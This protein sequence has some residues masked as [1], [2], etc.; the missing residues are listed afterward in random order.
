[1]TPHPEVRGDLV[2]VRMDE[3]GGAGPAAVR[4]LF[5]S[6]AIWRL[7]LV[8]GV[9]QQVL[10]LGAARLAGVELI[11]GSSGT[12]LRLPTLT[13]S[14]TVRM[15]GGVHDLA[16]TVPGG[17]PVRVRVGAG[18]GAVAVYQDRRDGVAAGELI[19]SPDWDRANARLYVD[20]VAGANTVTVA[21]G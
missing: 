12:R 16:V 14:L 8:G 21:E 19:S 18:A 6:R 4:V 15:T 17:A 9:D 5:N 10:D 20:L 7:R 1:M 11:G 3:T 13:G 2:R